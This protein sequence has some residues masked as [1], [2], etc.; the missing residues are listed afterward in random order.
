MSISAARIAALL[1]FIMARHVK[2]SCIRSCY[3]Q[4]LI[5]R[6]TKTELAAPNLWYLQLHSPEYGAVVV[7]NFEND[8][9]SYNHK[10]IKFDITICN[11]L[12]TLAIVF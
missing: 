4:S 11:G 2:T 1:E 9:Y 3:K 12:L 10:L 7:S 5:I 8:L 6:G